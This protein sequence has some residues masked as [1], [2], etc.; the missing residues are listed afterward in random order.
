LKSPCAAGRRIYAADEKQNPLDIGDFS[1]SWKND[2]AGDCI[3]NKKV[4]DG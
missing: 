3:L 1:F 4:I 2:N